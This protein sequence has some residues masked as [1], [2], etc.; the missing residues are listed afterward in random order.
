MI[1]YGY[2]IQ[3]WPWLIW[4]HMA[5]MALVPFWSMFTFQARH[6]SKGP[7]YKASF[8]AVQPLQPAENELVSVCLSW[9]SARELPID[10]EIMLKPG[11][12]HL[13]NSVLLQNHWNWR[14][15]LPTSNWILPPKM[16]IW[17]CT[18]WAF[19]IFGHANPGPQGPCFADISIVQVCG[20][21]MV[22]ADLFSYSISPFDAY[23]SFFPL[24]KH[25]IHIHGQKHLHSACLKL[26]FRFKGPLKCLKLSVKPGRGEIW[27]PDARNPTVM[28][29]KS[30]GTS[31]PRDGRGWRDLCQNMEIYNDWGLN[32]KEKLKLFGC[33]YLL[34][35]TQRMMFEMVFF[36]K[37][38][39]VR[40]LSLFS[41]IPLPQP[42]RIFC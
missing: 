4:I 22:F 14:Y 29:L 31:R 10:S 19:H 23:P 39:K 5:H 26:S 9:I 12:H 27:C 33:L 13:P 15:L 17:G 38:K 30:R 32:S 36:L 40:I 42:N 25:A 41:Q 28:P 35:E 21:L 24:Q 37:K 34:P 16:G 6:S 20:P 18:S 8:R 1:K 11:Q 3:F 2:I 7:F